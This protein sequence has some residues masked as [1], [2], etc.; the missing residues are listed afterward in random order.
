MSP[1]RSV[2]FV[3]VSLGS[4]HRPSRPTHRLFMLGLAFFNVG[5]MGESRGRARCHDEWEGTQPRTG[6]HDDWEGEPRDRRLF[7]R[8]DG[9]VECC[10]LE[11]VECCVLEGVEC[12]LEGVECMEGVV[13]GISERRPFS[14][15]PGLGPLF[16]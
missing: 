15:P 4:Q 7:D 13:Q 9:R 16:L 1:P 8:Q 3:G 2:F 6:C 14:M 10:V 5:S 11:G 12:M